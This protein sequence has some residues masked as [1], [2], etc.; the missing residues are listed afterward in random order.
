MI[1]AIVDHAKLLCVLQS[2]LNKGCFANLI[3][4]VIGPSIDPVITKIS[5]SKIPIGR[6]YVFVNASLTSSGSKGLISSIIPTPPEIKE[7]STRMC[8]A[9]K[10]QL[11]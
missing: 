9:L 3:D 7:V 1:V 2:A 10:D 6:F 4:I 5:K 11:M 8:P